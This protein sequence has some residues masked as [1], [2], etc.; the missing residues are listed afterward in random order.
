LRF[1]HE[2]LLRDVEDK[3]RGV[4]RVQGGGETVAAPLVV[5][6]NTA[7]AMVV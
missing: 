3:W 1:G 4:G 7:I 6:S 2:K 5:A